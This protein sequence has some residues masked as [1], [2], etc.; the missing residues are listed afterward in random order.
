MVVS[1]IAIVVFVD[2]TAVQFKSSQQPR[3]DK[4]VERAINGRATHVPS[5]SALGELF[6]QFVNVEVLMSLKNMLEQY[7]PLLR[8]S[9][10]SDLQEFF[11]SL[12]RR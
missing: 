10:A 4:F 6:N 9:H 5:F 2:R 7:F 12:L 8:H 11:E 1:R 3:F